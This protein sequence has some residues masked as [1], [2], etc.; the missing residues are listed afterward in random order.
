M[1]KSE[2][3][4]GFFKKTSN[5]DACTRLMELTLDHLTCLYILEIRGEE[6]QSR[7]FFAF[8]PAISEPETCRHHEQKEI[9]P[10]PAW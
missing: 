1:V 8:T 3:F 6:F 4:K 10:E 2:G 7:E 5:R 9:P